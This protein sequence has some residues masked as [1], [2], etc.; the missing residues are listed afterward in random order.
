MRKKY[1][2]TNSNLAKAARGANNQPGPSEA[3]FSS[4]ESKAGRMRMHALDVLTTLDFSAAC[5]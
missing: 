5:R 3:L 1:A 2:I 4:L